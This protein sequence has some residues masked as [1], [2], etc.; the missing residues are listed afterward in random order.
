MWT[1]DRER[2]RTAAQAVALALVAFAG[3][4]T[5]AWSQRT[6]AG[7]RIASLTL[8]EATVVVDPALTH[9]GVV[10]FPLYGVAD[11]EL[12]LFLEADGRRVKRL[13]WVQFE[14]YRPDN[15]H[16]YDY[17]DDPVTEVEG[18]GFHTSTRYY[19]S[20]DLP[21]RANSDGDHVVRLLRENGYELGADVARV[22]LVWLLNEP[23]R[24]ELM[25]IYMEDLADHGTS[26]AELDGS[27]DSWNE[28]SAGLRRRALEAFEISR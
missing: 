10:L 4:A 18:R 15:E 24:D 20:S 1:I 7:N 26:V 5:P 27:P 22:R 28:L 21:G 2:C 13:L 14:G 17:S 8:P 9:V 19:P 11:V 3:A 23:P 12:H 6:V 25:L 16:T